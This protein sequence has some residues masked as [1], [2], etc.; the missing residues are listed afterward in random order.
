MATG[1]GGRCTGASY[2]S[3]PDRGG[4]LSPLIPGSPSDERCRS[5]FLAINPLFRILSP[6]F[7]AGDVRLKRR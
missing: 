1:Y 4:A 7:D 2:A 6:Y 3:L 5:K